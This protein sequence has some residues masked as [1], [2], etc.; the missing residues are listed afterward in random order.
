MVGP[1]PIQ[2]DI[3]ANSIT[4]HS[5]LEVD[6]QAPAAID[7]IKNVD[8]ERYKKM[9]FIPGPTLEEFVRSIPTFVSTKHL[10]E[11]YKIFKDKWWSATVQSLEILAAASHAVRSGEM[12]I[13]PDRVILSGL[14]QTAD[15]TRKFILE[16]PHLRLPD[17]YAPFEGFM[18][19][20]SEGGEA[21]PDL[22]ESKIIE[23]LGELEINST[24][25]LYWVN[26]ITEGPPHRRPDSTS[27]RLYEVAG[28][29]HRETRYLSMAEKKRLSSLDLEGS[30]WSTFSNSFVYHA[31]FDA[32]DR[33]IVAGAAP[34]RGTT[35]EINRNWEVERDEHGNAVAGLRT[36][37]TDV[38]TGRLI[39]NSPRS[40]PHW[41]TCEFLT[42]YLSCSMS[43]T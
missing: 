28:M 24:K 30:Q 40:R 25:A 2:S 21:L 27:F 4:G 14:C 34:P 39:D 15:L 37:H 16:G 36:V 7:Q 32:M 5:W 23:I 8:P 33:W 38:P 11:D 26:G 20:Q 29:A 17:G 35:L 31:L 6:S 22:A 3:R 10:W 42:Y 13:D 12:G 19:C 9:H 18:P 1:I 43:L 41:Q